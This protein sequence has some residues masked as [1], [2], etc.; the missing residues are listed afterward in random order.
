M[1]Q[2]HSY[3]SEEGR[4]ICAAIT[5]VMTGV[6]YATSAEIASEVGAFPKYKKNKK[7]MLRVMRNHRLAAHGEAK[8]YKGLSILP[9]PLDASSCPDTDLV[10]A[11]RAAWDRGRGSGRGTWLPQCAGNSDCPDRNNRSGNG[12]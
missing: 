12:L 3:D 6:S 4:A 10:A 5:A 8:G 2:G 9:V 1:A 11:A 7:H